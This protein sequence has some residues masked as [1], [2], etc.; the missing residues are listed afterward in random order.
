L[1]PPKLKYFSLGHFANQ[2]LIVSLVVVSHFLILSGSTTVNLAFL[3]GE[4]ELQPV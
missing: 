3:T 4:P 1:V 2:A